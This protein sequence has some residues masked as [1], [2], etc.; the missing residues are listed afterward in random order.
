MSNLKQIISPV[1]ALIM[2]VTIYSCGRS[3]DS[4]ELNNNAETS[5]VTVLPETQLQIPSE[6]PEQAKEKAE[7]LLRSAQEIADRYSTAGATIRADIFKDTDLTEGDAEK[8]NFLAMLPD[9]F[10]GSG[11]WA[12]KMEKFII[13]SAVYSPGEGSGII[14]RCPEEYTGST[15]DITDISSFL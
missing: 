10:K 15:D 14:A 1:L 8:L 4:T 7:L 11:K 13:I 3:G 5:A 9:E 12:F 6:T 2:S